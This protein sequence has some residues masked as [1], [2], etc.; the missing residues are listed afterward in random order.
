MTN[1]QLFGTKESLYPEEGNTNNVGRNTG[2]L[3]GE[4]IG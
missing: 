4:T 3:E 2:S 1:C